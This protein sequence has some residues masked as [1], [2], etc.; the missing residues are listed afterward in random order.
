MNQRGFEMAVKYECPNCGADLRKK[1]SLYLEY[2][3]YSTN[4]YD[5]RIIPND[6]EGSGGALLLIGELYSLCPTQG[7]LLNVLCNKCREE[8]VDFEDTL[9]IEYLE[10]IEEDSLSKSDITRIHEMYDE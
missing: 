1:G 8:I 7:G 5:G 6:D 9:D 10:E 3:L 2:G 4:D